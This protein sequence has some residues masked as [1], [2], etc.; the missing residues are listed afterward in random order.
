MIFT[1]SSTNLIVQLLYF[2]FGVELMD[3]QVFYSRL[4][5]EHLLDGS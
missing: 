2:G 4:A 3:R 5:G 1:V